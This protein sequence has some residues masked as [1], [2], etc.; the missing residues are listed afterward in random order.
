MKLSITE[1]HN[2]TGLDRRRVR[3]ALADLESTPGKKGAVMYESRE[4]LPML[5]VTGD[6][7]D[8]RQEQARLNHHRA[9]LAALDE[10]KAKGELIEVEEV[11]EIVGADYA[12]LRA[13][14]LAMPTKGSPELLGIEDIAVAHS[15]VERLVVDALKE[16]TADEVYS[17]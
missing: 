7:L 3:A 6:T 15:I 10:R 16:L 1:L 4:A 11:A 5:Y 13:K 12:N 14:L 17:P 9:N 2:L 8:P